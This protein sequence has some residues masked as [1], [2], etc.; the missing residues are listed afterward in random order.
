MIPAGPGTPPRHWASK[1]IMHLNTE[2]RSRL[3]VRN[4]SEEH[5]SELQSLMRTSYAV[6]CLKKKKLD[7]N[8]YAEITSNDH[9]NASAQ[10]AHLAIKTRRKDTGNSNEQQ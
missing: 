8:D 2:W 3:S 6:F 7:D 1:R 4:R 10:E 9:I 5:T